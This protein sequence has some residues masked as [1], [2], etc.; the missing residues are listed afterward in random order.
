MREVRPAAV[1]ARLGTADAPLLL[2]VREAWELDEACL[3]GATHV[4]LGELPT[5]L[6][7]LPRDREIVVFCHH[8]GRSF[9]AALLLERAG[10]QATNLAGGI[11]AWARE[12]DPAIPA[13]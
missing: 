7:R 3:D 4:P 2:D 6:D 9:T 10:F 11:D 5:A 13:Y 8:G 1:A 12:V